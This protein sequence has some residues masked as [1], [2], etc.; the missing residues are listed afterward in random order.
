MPAQRKK[1]SVAGWPFIH[2]QSRKKK[3]GGETS[4]YSFDLGGKEKEKKNLKKSG[5]VGKGGKKRNQITISPSFANKFGK[6]G[7]ADSLQKPCGR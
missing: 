4:F 5:C 2:S 6:K 1:K 7:K 3:K